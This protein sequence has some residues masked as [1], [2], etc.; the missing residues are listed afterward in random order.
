MKVGT[1]MRRE[2]NMDVIE[3]YKVTFMGEGKVSLIRCLRKK[4]NTK[5]N[6]G[7]EP[8]VT[9]LNLKKY[10]QI[11]TLSPLQKTTLSPP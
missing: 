9:V 3:S 5:I 6:V 10:H 4:T 11:S 1:L 7:A 8:L 2:N